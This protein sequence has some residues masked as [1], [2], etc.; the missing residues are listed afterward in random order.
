[1]TAALNE[2]SKKL[3]N[4]DVEVSK[5]KAEVKML[6]DQLSEKERELQLK[7]KELMDMKNS[8]EA[9]PTTQQDE[10]EPETTEF[11][12][13]KVFSLSSLFHI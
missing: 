7:Q 1:M 13:L 2:Q 10:V 3:A 4:Y 6:K 11:L 9:L 12:A 5:L 8:P